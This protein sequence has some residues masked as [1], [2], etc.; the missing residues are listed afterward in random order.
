MDFSHFISSNQF[1]RYAIDHRETREARIV[2]RK[3]ARIKRNRLVSPEIP[4]DI[5]SG[6]HAT[7]ANKVIAF[8]SGEKDEARWKNILTKGAKKAISPTE[9]VG[10]AFLRAR[11]DWRRL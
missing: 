6:D 7:S 2:T 8:V 3:F 4:S 11:E 9:P 5:S 10:L 1:T